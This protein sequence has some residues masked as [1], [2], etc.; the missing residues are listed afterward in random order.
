M[1]DGFAYLFTLLSQVKTPFLA[2]D[3]H[4]AVNLAEPHA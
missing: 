3:M 4:P 1:Q 2:V